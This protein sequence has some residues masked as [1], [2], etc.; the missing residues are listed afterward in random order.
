MA[1]VRIVGKPAIPYL[2][3]MLYWVDQANYRKVVIPFIE[4]DWHRWEALKKVCEAFLMKE[5]AGAI[6]SLQNQM[7]C[8]QL[9]KIA[10]CGHI[11]S[12]I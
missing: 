11:E 9:V 3:L 5:L 4:S 12:L 7:P 6:D 1:L 2:K 8:G 10:A